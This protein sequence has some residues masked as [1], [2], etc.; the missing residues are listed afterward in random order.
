[1]EGSK[2][3]VVATVMPVVKEEIVTVVFICFTNNHL[4]SVSTAVALAVNSV[5]GEVE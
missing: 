5:A 2:F 1:M 3:S 4:P